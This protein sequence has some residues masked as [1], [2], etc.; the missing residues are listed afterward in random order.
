MRA[1]ITNNC[2]RFSV[3]IF[4]ILLVSI[5]FMS[6]VNLLLIE[7]RYPEEGVSNISPHPD[8]TETAFPPTS[9]IQPR[10]TRSLIDEYNNL[11]D[12]RDVLVVRNLN[13]VMSMEIAD[14]FQAQRDIPQINICN[15][16]TSTSETITR[17]T[18]ENE[19]RV[20][21]ENHII[22]NGLLGGINFI[23][24]TKDVPLRVSELDPSDDA[25]Y[26]WDRSSV[27]SD[28]AL[29]L[30][31]Y[32]PQIGAPFW[33]ENPYH[34]ISPYQ[35][36]SF[37]TYGYFL[38]TR[39]TGYNT[40]EAKGLL[41]KVPEAVGRKGTFVL[42]GDPGRDG[43]GYQVG[44]D[45]MRNANATLTANGFDSYL[46]E[47]TT[48]L[49]NQA[50][51]SGY[52]SWG[53][54][55]G[56]Y[57]KNSVLNSGLETDS[58]GNEVP[59]N[60]YFK[61]EGTIGFCERN[62]TEVRNGAWSVKITRNATSKNATFMSQNYTVKPDTR[63]YAVGYVNLSGVSTEGGVHLQF[64][65]F[66]S[67]GKVIQF[68][69]GSV[70]T[71]TTTGWVSLYQVH[72]EPVAGVTNISIGV[73]LS[74]SSGT[75]FV[76]DVYL[77]EIKP[78]NDWV[79]GALAETIVSTSAR[80]LNYPTSYGQSLISDI[81]RDGVTGVKGYVYEP[82]LDA[83]AHPDI[84]FDSFT[85]GYYMAE[86][87][88]MASRF[89]GW[90]DIVVGDPKLAVY[91]QHMIPDLAIQSPD[92][93]FSD[94]K[95]GEGDLVTIYVNVS[96]LGN[97]TANDVVVHFFAGD[98]G[99]GGTYVGE[100]VLSIPA[101]SQNLT[102]LMWNTTGFT[103]SQDIYI[104]VDAPDMYF[105]LDE[106]NNIAFKQIDIVERFQLQLH[107]GWN[108]VSLPLAQTDTSLSSI[109]GPILGQYDAVQAY[110]ISDKNN[111]WKHHHE[112]KPITLNDLDELDHLIGFW[113]HITTP[114]IIDFNV[115]GEQFSSNQTTPLHT[116]W[117]QVGFPSQGNKNRTAGL[118]NLDFGIE[119]DAI[120]TFDGATQTWEEVGPLDS[121]KL[122]KGYWIHATQE[123]VWEVPL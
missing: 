95:P 74:E 16:T 79:P 108:L 101:L 30:G 86:S 5:L 8:K 113:I 28:L 93:S 80:S 23:V 109:L 44:N 78:H 39:L 1:R 19:I 51:V 106:N 15:I 45:W 27:D 100:S 46:D 103:G 99:S 43:G 84:L 70:R 58:D 9:S 34:D 24:T 36:F 111:L 73:S 3:S 40:T 115:T 25:S 2:R 49:T 69:N 20:P 26:A 4:T 89:I 60:W 65:A 29:I 121:F 48:F 94:E 96:N 110:N 11:V 53:S 18:F 81:I 14:Y 66:D 52:A 6:H 33:V 88:Y 37:N 85:Q 55:D 104:Y 12:Y 97:F 32:A 10:G 59:D 64:R 61:N 98:P 71:G 41:D 13:S 118:N 31:P 7:N 105:E 90:M 92:I 83:I 91:K 107:N 123:C 82:F 38:V 54:N 75:V 22:N 117:N 72:F 102:Y 56:N 120:F 112:S 62:G 114:G 50:N 21:V 63:Y 57:P 116:G 68:Y 77:Y 67:Q 47:T 35:D 42:D 87:Y 17:T 76:D 122:E 119:V